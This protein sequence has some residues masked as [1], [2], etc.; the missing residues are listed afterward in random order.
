MPAHI[1][2]WSAS[3]APSRQPAPRRSG[4]GGTLCSGAGG[5]VLA[6]R[7]PIARAAARQHV[8][9]AARLRAR[10][11]LALRRG[12]AVA[13][14]VAAPQALNAAG[15]DGVPGRRSRAFAAADARL[16]RRSL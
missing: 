16:G 7:A 11:P 8:C 6:V 9:H 1:Q 12:G 2:A 4:L 15:G 10:H 13:D 14:A 5:A 3:A